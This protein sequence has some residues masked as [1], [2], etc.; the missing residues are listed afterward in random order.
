VSVFARPAYGG[1]LGGPA[2]R[3]GGGGGRPLWTPFSVILTPFRPVFVGLVDGARG[4]LGFASL[5]PTYR[6]VGLPTGGKEVCREAA[7]LN[8]LT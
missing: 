1:G 2:T 5:Y 4:L 7:Y 3:L 6:G 8:R